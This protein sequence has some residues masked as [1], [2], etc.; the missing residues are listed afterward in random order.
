LREL[1]AYK[2]PPVIVGDV[3]PDLSLI[4]VKFDPLS[5][6]LV[7]SAASNHSW[8]PDIEVG[9]KP[10]LNFKPGSILMELELIRMRPIHEP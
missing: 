8:Q 4:A 3:T 10:V 7:R 1:L 2:K 5:V 9:V 6:R